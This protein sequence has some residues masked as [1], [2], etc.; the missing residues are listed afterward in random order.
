ME[1]RKATRR[2]RN[3]I[4]FS[5]VLAVG[6]LGGGVCAQSLAAGEGAGAAAPPAPTPAGPANSQ[7]NFQGDRVAFHSRLYVEL[8]DGTGSHDAD[9]KGNH[10]V[11]GTDVGKTC[12]A[13]SDCAGSG[14]TCYRVLKN[15]RNICI[16]PDVILRGAG[17]NAAGDVHFVIV[18]CYTKKNCRTD[19]DG[20]PIPDGS[21]ITITRAQI[22]EHPPDRNGLSYGALVV[23]FKFQLTG[24]HQFTSSA[25]LGPYCGYKW[26]LETLGGAVTV[27]VFAAISNNAVTQTTNTQTTSPTPAPTAATTISQRS[28]RMTTI[29]SAQSSAQTTTTTTSSQSSTQQLAG[30]SYG[31]AVL[32][33]IKGGFQIGGVVGFDN[34]GSNTGFQYN[35]KPWL[36]VEIGYSFSQ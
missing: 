30:F 3:R 2:M 34:V 36:A 5:A 25:S 4:L 14:A 10:C 20:N 27:G 12:S 26:D 9:P 17:Q 11:G 21:V 15:P 24:A 22:A 32:G 23:P 19:C 18:S 7:S 29:T 33:E 31:V 28:T 8:D 13:D 16:T 6:L 1:N 35:N